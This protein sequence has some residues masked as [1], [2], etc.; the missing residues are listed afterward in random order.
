M[1]FGLLSIVLAVS[2]HATT[3]QKLTLDDMIRQSTAIVHVKVSSSSPVM[4]GRNIYTFYQFQ[5]LETLKAGGGAQTEVA[6]PGGST[7][8]LRQEV[9]GAPSL[10]AGGEYVIFLWTSNSGLTQ[11]I[12]LSQGL[13]SVLPDSSGTA[14]LVRGALAGATLVNKSGQTLNPLAV[15]ISLS[16]LKA[17]IQKVLGN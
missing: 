5:L 15:T 1:R 6:V 7:A 2:L 10:A 13:F 14:E 12:G 16:G 4:R 3:L 11:I 17:E 9:A 8:G